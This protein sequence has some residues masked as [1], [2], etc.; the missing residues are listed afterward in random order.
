M[1]VSAAPSM[2]VSG[3]TIDET[4]AFGARNLSFLMALVRTSDRDDCGLRIFMIQNQGPHCARVPSHSVTTWMRLASDMRARCA[5]DRSTLGVHIQGATAERGG[6]VGS[7]H[8]GAR[9]GSD[10]SDE[11]ARV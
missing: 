3:E 4:I 9:T 2:W 7:R 1:T 10:G 11:A 8:P 5:F 6:A